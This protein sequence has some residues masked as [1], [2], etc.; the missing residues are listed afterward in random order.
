[1]TTTAQK[2]AH[3]LLDNNAV[4]ISTNPP[5]IWTSGLKSPIYCDN[6]LLISYPEARKTIVQG[7]VEL[8]KKENIAFDVLGGTATAAIP[9]AAFLAYELNMPMVYIRPKPKEHGT[10]CQVE[11]TLPIGARVLIV[12]DLISTGKSS[13]ASAEACRREKNAE[14]AGIVSIFTYEMASARAALTEAGIPA[15]TLSTFSTLVGMLDISPSEKETIMKFAEDPAG[16]G[17]GAGKVKC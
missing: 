15:Y 6:R 3:I 17:V 5:F 13:I 8:I 12:E 14:I 16:W 2:V 9:W 10:G 4:K 7:F 1:M 11:G